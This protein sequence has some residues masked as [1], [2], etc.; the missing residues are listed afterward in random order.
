MGYIKEKSIW[1]LT[2]A[3]IHLPKMIDTLYK[4]HLKNL[5]VILPPINFVPSM[6]QLT[7]KLFIGVVKKKQDQLT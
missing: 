6:A 7:V 2:L 4:D 1:E 5:I 3:I